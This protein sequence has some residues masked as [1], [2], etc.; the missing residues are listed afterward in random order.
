MAVA[1]F[2]H[3]KYAAFYSALPRQKDKFSRI[4]ETY[5]E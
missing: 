2:D 4:Y 3:N 1:R 5:S